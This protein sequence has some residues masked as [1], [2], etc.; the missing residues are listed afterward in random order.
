MNPVYLSDKDLVTFLCVPRYRNWEPMF[1]W[2]QH[3]NSTKSLVCLHSVLIP[4]VL[5]EKARHGYLNFVKQKGKHNCHFK[6]SRAA[7]KQ[8]WSV[9]LFLGLF[10]FLFFNQVSNFKQLQALTG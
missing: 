4:S 9:V 10:L 2:N 3:E 5:R 6:M 8:T 1:L 7:K